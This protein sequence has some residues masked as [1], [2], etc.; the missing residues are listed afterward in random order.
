MPR[1]ARTIAVRE[2]YQLLALSDRPEAVPTAT[3]EYAVATLEGALL[4]R[5]LRLDEARRWLDR[6]AEEHVLRA[7]ASPAARPRR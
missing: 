1:Y 4:R 6:L 5:A 2:S 3:S 7:P